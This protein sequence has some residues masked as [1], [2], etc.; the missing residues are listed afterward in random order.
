[1]GSPG[2]TAGGVAVVNVD[3]P[4]GDGMAA[5]AHAGALRVSADGRA[6][7]IRV[8]EQHS[9]VRG[10]TAR[11]ATPRGELAVSAPPLIGHYN[12]ANL[13]LAVGIAEALAI[14]HEAIARGIA[15]LPG[16]PG[17]VERVAITADLGADLD[18][19]VDYAHTPD[20]L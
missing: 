4:E 6:A 12:V 14:P 7:E 18:V 13:A 17:R 2:T 5:A 10:I 19:F 3:D 16:V 11:I 20:A 8:I 9:T 1:P 15:E